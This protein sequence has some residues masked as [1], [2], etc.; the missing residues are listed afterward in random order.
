MIPLYDFLVG[1]FG[2]SVLTFLFMVIYYESKLKKLQDRLDTSPQEFQ[3]MV[4]VGISALML[5]I[6]VPKILEE[7]GINGDDES[8][9]KKGGIRKMVHF[10]RSK[11]Y[12]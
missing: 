11:V 12:G 8:E 1:V 9:P 7:M 4:G 2:G 3:K 5:G 10:I 6:M